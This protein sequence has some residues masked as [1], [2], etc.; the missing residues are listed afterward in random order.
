M[1]YRS[2]ESGN[3]PTGRLAAAAIGGGPAIAIANCA[4]GIGERV[5]MRSTPAG[6]LAGQ[7]G[8]KALTSHGSQADVMLV[9]HEQNRRNALASPVRS[10]ALTLGIRA[11]A[12]GR[13]RS[14]A[15]HER[16]VWCLD[17]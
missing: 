6:G 12:P 10:Q 11:R 17:M 5:T 8:S 15:R 13:P 7:A 14:E 3:G 4:A 1:R 16:D 2:V 9:I